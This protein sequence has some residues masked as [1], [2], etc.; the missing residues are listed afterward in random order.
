M[1]QKFYAITLIFN[2]CL[3]LDKIMIRLK[4][5]KQFGKIKHWQILHAYICIHSIMA[6]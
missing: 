2:M 5:E 6:D 1:V 3:Q 4:S